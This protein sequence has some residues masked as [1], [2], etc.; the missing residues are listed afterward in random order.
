M[1]LGRG[2]CLLSLS[3]SDWRVRDCHSLL[4]FPKLAD[5]DFFLLN[6][7]QVSNDYCDV[8]WVFATCDIGAELARKDLGL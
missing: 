4:E 6:P 3:R 1:V 8:D 5:G 2:F 7:I